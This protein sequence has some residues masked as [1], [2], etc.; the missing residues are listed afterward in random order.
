MKPL[1]YARRDGM[2]YLVYV[3]YLA[4]MVGITRFL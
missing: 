4:V 3:G 2:A 1:K